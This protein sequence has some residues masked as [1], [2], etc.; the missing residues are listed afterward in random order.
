MERITWRTPDGRWGVRDIP[1][2]EIDHRLYGALCKLKAYEDNELSP[3]EVAMLKEERE[4]DG[5]WS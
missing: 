2:D 5:R 4:E 1:W 3:D